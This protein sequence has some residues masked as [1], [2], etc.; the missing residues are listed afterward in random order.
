MPVFDRNGVHSGGDTIET[1]VRSRRR[2]ARSRIGQ[3]RERACA[4]RA[5]GYR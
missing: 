1:V 3:R 2:L 5:M 4:A